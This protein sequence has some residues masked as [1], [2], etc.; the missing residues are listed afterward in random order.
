MPLNAQHKRVRKNRVSIT[1]DVETGDSQEKR[2]LPFVVGVTGNFSGDKPQD[3]LEPF[4]DREFIQVDHDNFDEVMN[5]I[6]PSL[7]LR[8]ENVLSN[9]PEASDMQ[10]NLKFNRMQDF[11]PDELVNQVEPLKMLV[12]IRNQLRVLLSKAD[13]ST[14]FEKLICKILKDDESIQRLAG[15]LGIE[16]PKLEAPDDEKS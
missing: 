5:R 2:E 4:E 9:D 8:V 10:V 12:N 16:P 11:S 14:D 6:G 13:R 15:E 7:N 3:Q 1:Y